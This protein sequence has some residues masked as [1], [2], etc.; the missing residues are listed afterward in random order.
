MRASQFTG[1]F[2]GN[3]GTSVL[4]PSQGADPFENSTPAPKPGNAGRAGITFSGAIAAALPR[5]SNVDAG[6]NSINLTGQGQEVFKRRGERAADQDV[7]NY[8]SATEQFNINAKA[9]KAAEIRNYDTAVSAYQKSITKYEAD[10]LRYNKLQAVLNDRGVQ[11]TLGTLNAIYGGPVVNPNNPATVPFG[12]NPGPGTRSTLNGYSVFYSPN[13]NGIGNY[14]RARDF[15]ELF[16]GQFD[17]HNQNTIV[18]PTASN[19]TR[20]NPIV[21]LR[22]TKDKLPDVRTRSIGQGQR[23]ILNG[24]LPSVAPNESGQTFE[25]FD[26]NQLPGQYYGKPFDSFNAAEQ[27]RLGAPKAYRLPSKYW[28]QNGQSGS[29]GG[30]TISPSDITNQS[31]TDYYIRNYGWVLKSQLTPLY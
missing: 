17:P 20:P 2:G 30:Q 13:N 3:R 8:N 31:S 22:Q 9:S 23:E 14:I 7:T 26:V 12:S 11:D 1:G 19:L 16:T 4:N 6:F 29:S 21:E 24:D 28:T 5:A 15:P 10:Q 25:V 18:A 27:Q